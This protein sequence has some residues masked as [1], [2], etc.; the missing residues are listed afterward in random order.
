IRR[1]REAVAAAYA[2]RDFEPIWLSGGDWSP[3]GRAVLARLS[4]AREDG[5]DLSQ[6]P[7]PGLT[8]DAPGLAAADLAL[9]QAVVGYARQASGGRIEPRALSALITSK[10]EVADPAS[11]LA[12]VASASDAGEALSAFN[13]PHPGYKALRQK[14]E[15][16]RREKPAMAR[17]NITPGPVL[18][19]GMKDPRVPLIRATFGMDASADGSVDQLTYDT[20]VASAVADFQRA[21][22]L[23]ANGTLTART[24]SALSGG[25]PAQL[26]AEI[27]AN[28]ERWRWLP[29]D[30]GETRIEVNIPDYE[31]KLSRGD[32]VVHRTRV[33][34]GKPDTPTPIFS[35]A[36][37]YIVVNPYWN[38]PT[39]IIKKEMLPAYQ[40]DPSYFSRR[41]YEVIERKGQIIVRQPPGERNALGLIKFIFPNEHSVYLHDTPSRGLFS[42]ARRAFSHGC[43]RVFQPFALAEALLPPEYTEQR[44][45]KMVGGGEKTVRLPQHIPIHL[46]YFTAYVDADGKLQVRDDIYGYSRRVRAALGV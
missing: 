17:Q 41:G 11:V 10:P 19:V 18:K 27:L 29:R 9:S 30:L 38:V 35:D 21:N 40:R 33:I 13:P 46:Q 32:K 4:L 8:D 43:V 5:L 34:V 44:L 2:Q 12:T 3:A 45:R 22:G 42:S 6:Y 26:E 25:H 15:E 16:I 39:S 31:A 24:I 23:P 14:L 7:L 37:E 28:M 1:E 36:M 20:R